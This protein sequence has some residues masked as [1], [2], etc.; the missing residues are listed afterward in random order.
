[1]ELSVESWWLSILVDMLS[2]LITS[3][4]FFSCAPV[5]CKQLYS[6]VVL[7]VGNQSWPVC[8]GPTSWRCCRTGEAWRL[9]SMRRSDSPSERARLLL[10]AC[11]EEIGAD[12][13]SG[14]ND[15]ISWLAWWKGLYCCL[16]EEWAG[17]T[18]MNLVPYVGIWPGWCLCHGGPLVL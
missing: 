6:Q 18:H 1:M 15:S 16:Q 17:N 13:R 3:A 5:L 7:T 8:C 11:R 10:H 2:S 4:S 14:R 12:H 9:A